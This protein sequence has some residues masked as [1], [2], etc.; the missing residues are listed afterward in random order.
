MIRATKQMWHI[1]AKAALHEAFVMRG[2]SLFTQRNLARVLR[3]VKAADVAANVEIGKDG[4]FRVIA[5]RPGDKGDHPLNEWDGA[6]GK[7]STKVR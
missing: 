4:T 1:A 5:V 7:P 6:L 2:P 3:A